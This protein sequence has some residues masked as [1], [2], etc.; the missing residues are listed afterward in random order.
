MLGIK[1]RDRG[2]VDEKD[3]SLDV[4]QLGASVIYKI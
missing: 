3:K 4:Y 2:I 1:F